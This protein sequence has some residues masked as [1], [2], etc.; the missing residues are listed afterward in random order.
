MLLR[1]EELINGCIP[2]LPTDERAG[3]DEVLVNAILSNEGFDGGEVM[4]VDS[5]V[6]F[7][8]DMRSGSEGVE[9]GVGGWRWNGDGRVV[10]RRR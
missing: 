10:G 8:Y 9:R 4:A 3:K 7:P 6:K 2:Y 5:V 1:A